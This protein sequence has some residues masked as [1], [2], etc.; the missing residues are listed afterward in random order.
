MQN[1]LQTLLYKNNDDP[2]N[3]LAAPY[4]TLPSVIQ[5]ALLSRR[6]IILIANNPSITQAKLEALLQP[7]DMLVLFNDFI[8]AEFF[9]SHPVAKSLP[10]LLF[11]RQI[12]DSSLHFGLPPRSNSVNAIDKMAQQ[13]PLGILLGNTA[14]QFPAPCD[15]PRPN[16]DPVTQERTIKVPDRLKHLLYSDEHCR[17]LSERHNVVADYPSFTHIHSSAPTSGFLVY[18]LMLAT[19]L[20]VSQLQPDMTPL[21][22]LMLGFNDSDKT[23][24]FWEGHNWGFERQELATPP[25]Y[26]D[27][28][29]RY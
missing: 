11:F 23:A 28:I 18:R 6:R 21:Q 7:D 9:A 15:D 2:L 5:E 16:D 3:T 24:H 12:G 8:H 25:S 4:Q 26:V 29:R 1:T 14:Y 20:Q 13:A 19:R 10:K 22:I 27:V 17:V